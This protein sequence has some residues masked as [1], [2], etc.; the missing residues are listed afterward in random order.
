M[1]AADL[2]AEWRELAACAR[3]DADLREFFPESQGQTG[4]VAKRICG[5]C[6]VNRQCLES[7]LDGR[8]EW[9]IWGGAGEQ[10]RR[11]LARLYWATRDI[12]HPD[13]CGC[14]FHAAV[15]R[16]FR[17]LEEFVSTGVLPPGAQETFGP[18]ATHGRSSTAAKGCRCPRCSLASAVRTKESA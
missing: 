15:S 18:G 6:P 17:R 3:A 1:T 10:L 4:Y 14:R 8:E 11:P 13:G 16:H 2:S 9:G 7:A 12:G 5:T